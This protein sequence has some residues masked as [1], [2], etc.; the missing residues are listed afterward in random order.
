MENVQIAAVEGR[1]RLDNLGYP[2]LGRSQKLPGLLAS[3]WGVGA[4]AGYVVDKNGREGLG[5][6]ASNLIHVAIVDTGV[7]LLSMIGYNGSSTKD[8]GK[9][10]D[11]GLLVGIGIAIG[12]GIGVRV[13]GRAGRVELAITE[14]DKPW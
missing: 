10:T 2:V 7:E 5:H 13:R 4:D 8:H 14:D 1:T 12:I 3:V 9:N 6:L 11:V